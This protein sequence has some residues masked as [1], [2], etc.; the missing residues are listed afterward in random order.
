MALFD[1]KDLTFTFPGATVPALDR[2]SLTV[3]AGSYVCLCGKSG[4]GK[5][6]LLRQL[7]SVLTPVGERRGAVLFNGRP[8]D[9]IDLR[10][11]SRFIGFVM[12]DPDAQVV[13]DK[14]WHELAFGL[15]S[16]GCP[17]QTMRVRV[18]EMASYF[19]IQHWYHKD[20]VE[21]SGGQKQLLNLA[22]VMAMQPSVLI[23]DE[24]TS[25][26]DPI[27]ASD[28]LNTVR[29][30]NRELGTTVLIT[31]HRLEDAF[32][33]ADEVVVMDAG[34][35]SVSGA[36]REVGLALKRAGDDMAFALPAPMRICLGVEEGRGQ[37]SLQRDDAGSIPLTVREGRTWL[38]DHAEAHPVK[39]RALP[40]EEPLGRAEDPVLCVKDAWFR[41]E[42]DAPDVLKGASLEVAR[43][44]LRAIMGG[45]GTGKSTLLKAIC[46]ICKPYRGRIWVL[47]KRLRAWKER[48][49]FSGGI[50]LLPQDPQ[51]LFVKK[52]VRDDLAEMLRAAPPD[53]REE[54][55]RGIALT[56]GIDALL[57]Q[58]PF[59]L[60]GGEQ[61][62]T[63]LAKVLLSEP[64]LLFLDEPTKGIDGFF[65]RELAEVLHGLIERGVSIVMVSHDVEFCARYATSVSLFFDGS[66]VTTDAPRAFF[67]ENSFYTTAANRMS[68]QVFANAVTDEEVIE[69]CRG[70]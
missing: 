5:T 65:K 48:D 12:Q 38:L 32:A 34:S 10:D 39:V 30:I 42:R 47:G 29:K 4:S 68:R 54:R 11:Q 8:L 22:S 53:E 62:R 55:V 69:L 45:N 63:A 18:A 64:E 46:G 28:F 19:G 36:P 35:I 37:G 58:H 15:E 16:V 59:D 52:T 60:S 67:S 31:E 56:C 26:L 43:G 49:L 50:A 13:T 27:A 21:L 3:E 51:N 2:V 7:R 40:R 41:Y 25:Q 6:T 66:I 1:I 23:L 33:A 9:G 17:P 14:V 24:P 57:D 20:V 61:Q 70:M 44:E